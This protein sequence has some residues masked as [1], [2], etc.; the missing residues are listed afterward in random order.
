MNA[1][2]VTTPGQP[3][4]LCKGAGCVVFPTGE[5]V[6]DRFNDKGGR[7]DHVDWNPLPEW[8]LDPFRPLPAGR[9]F[10]RSPLPT[11][12]EP[13]KP[14]KNDREVRWA[15]DFWASCQRYDLAPAV[16]YAKARGIPVDRLPGGRLPITIRVHGAH[17]YHTTDPESGCPLNLGPSPCMVGSVCDY[18]RGAGD[19]LT[20]CQ[21]VYLDPHE[22]G[23]KRGDVDDPKKCRGPV[24]GGAVWLGGAFSG[25]DRF[26][27]GVLVLCEGI[28]TG[29]AILAATGFTTWACVSTHGL[30]TVEIPPEWINDAEPIVRQVVVA[31]DHDGLSGETEHSPAFRP[32]HRAAVYA[33][34][35][36]RLKFPTLD[37]AIAIPQHKDAPSRVGPHVA[38]D[39]F[40]EMLAGVKGADWLDV[41]TDPAHKDG[42]SAVLEGIAR[43]R[44]LGGAARP[45]RE[46][47][48]DHDA[49]GRD[50]D[51]AHD[52]DG[53]DH[54]GADGGPH[55]CDEEESDGP[56]LPRGSL[57]RARV[58]LGELWTPANPAGLR[59]N[60][61]YHDAS[62]RWLEWRGTHYQSVS[63]TILGA[64]MLARFEKYRQPNKEGKPIRVAMSARQCGD[65]LNAMISDVAVAGEQ[66]PCWA[67]PSFDARGRAIYS[68]GERPTSATRDTEAVMRPIPYLNGLLRLDTLLSEGR[69]VVDPASNRYVIPYCLPYAVPE[70]DLARAL[71]GDGQAADVLN[72]LCPRWL[73][74]LAEVSDGDE[75]WV[76]CLGRFLGYC[77]TDDTRFQ[78]ALFLVGQPGAGKGTIL[79]VLH[80]LVGP[81]CVLSSSFKSLT[82]RFEMGALVGKLVLQL[83]EAAVGW[84][85]DSIEASR[86]FKTLTGGAMITPEHKH[87]GKGGSY[88][89]AAKMVATANELPKLPEASGATSRRI[90]I[91]P[92][93][94][95]FEG[96]SDPHLRD[97]LASEIGGICVW[98][99]LN[100]VELHKDGVFPEPG[101]SVELKEDFRRL[102]SPVYAFTRDCCVFEPR[103]EVDT[104]LLLALFKAWCQAEDVN[105]MSAEKFGTMLRVVNASVRKRKVSERSTGRR[106]S[107]YTGVRP[108]VETDNAMDGQ[109]PKSLRVTS[110]AECDQFD[111]PFQWHPDAEGPTFGSSY[112]RR[113]DGPGYRK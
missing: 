60:I 110:S 104:R 19:R 32:G 84:S 73:Q 56:I 90:L 109:E 28:E 42:V 78:K 111:F 66:L 93:N 67:P 13:K 23:R 52:D 99:L 74:F 15:R 16:A 103:S 59:W 106:Y 65:V 46:S 68:D 33:A 36:L 4:P 37:V 75:R 81:E 96:R 11:L 9:V 63:P 12:K 80:L 7:L 43:A 108:R 100:L 45:P 47:A 76:S 49:G 87:K 27:G 105:G 39:G 14:D 102:A 30:K 62:D 77:M 35:R 113:D 40:D 95:S 70:A 69:V 5:V 88:R 82:E 53:G 51:D 8:M 20:A 38:D 85:T 58:A 107:V 61:A 3:C 86:V 54:D 101:D 48:G 21:R 31:A 1:G 94:T 44:S 2:R 22:P 71:E 112:E 17:D 64:S 50:D 29:L 89:P 92:F 25:P 41:L 91:L 83:D 18:T 72:R 55:V 97:K 6:C 24:T 34:R 26:P 79:D 98:A 57:A 10:T